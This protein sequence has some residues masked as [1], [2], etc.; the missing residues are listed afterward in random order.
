MIYFN[1]ISPNPTK[2]SNTLKQFVSSLAMKCVSVF[3]HFM[4][5]WL[6]GLTTLIA[7]HI[8]GLRRTQDPHKYLRWKA[9]QQQLMLLALM[10]VGNVSLS[11]LFFWKHSLSSFISK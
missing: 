1:P 7:F 8:C 2:W 11:I 10:V 9:L 5:F 3:Y 6:K 4:R